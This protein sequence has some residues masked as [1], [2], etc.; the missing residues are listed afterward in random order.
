MAQHAVAESDLWLVLEILDGLPA[1]DE[2]HLRI[3]RAIAHGRR[4]SLAG[5]SVRWIALGGDDAATLRAHLL[6]ARHRF[7]PAERRAIDRIAGRL[8]AAP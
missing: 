8:E 6:R 2:V 1:D 4:A 7:G 5:G 3:R